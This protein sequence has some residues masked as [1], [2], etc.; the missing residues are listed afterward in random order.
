[1]IFSFE[2]K[3]V[4]NN[5]CL[6]IHF[7]C[8]QHRT[9]HGFGMNPKQTDKLCYKIMNECRRRGPWRLVLWGVNS[10]LI[11]W[12]LNQNLALKSSEQVRKAAC[13][14]EWTIMR[15]AELWPRESSCFR[16]AFLAS[17][18]QSE[19]VASS[20]NMTKSSVWLK[21]AWAGCSCLPVVPAPVY[22]IRHR[23]VDSS[24]SF[25]KES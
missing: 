11:Q 2:M 13:V 24:H 4:I 17:Q 12:R 14:G 21:M 6:F 22:A 20:G 7:F 23:E 25:T 8:K 10:V 3:N 18:Q 1:M 9:K 19:V 5:N 15:T 16:L